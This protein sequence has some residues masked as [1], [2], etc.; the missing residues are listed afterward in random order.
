MLDINWNPALANS[1]YIYATLTHSITRSQP[2]ET[3][4]RQIW[5][6]FN[7]CMDK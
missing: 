7:P 6:N 1:V 2:N 4:P 5:I 3:E